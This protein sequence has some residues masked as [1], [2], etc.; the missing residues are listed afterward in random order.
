MPRNQTFDMLDFM[1]VAYPVL[2]VAGVCSITVSLDTFLN[3]CLMCMLVAMCFFAYVYMYRK[4][5]DPNFG[6]RLRQDVQ[7]LARYKER[8][9]LSS[10]LSI[11]SQSGLISSM[12]RRA[13][14]VALSAFSSNP[15]TILAEWPLYSGFYHGYPWVAYII[16]LAYSTS[17][18]WWE[19]A[20][21]AAMRAFAALQ[22]AII[23]TEKWV[24]ASKCRLRDAVVARLL[25]LAI[26]IMCIENWLAETRDHLCHRCIST[27]DAAIVYL[28]QVGSIVKQWVVN[29]IQWMF[30]QTCAFLRG[31]WNAIKDAAMPRLQRFYSGII[32]WL[33]RTA[34]AIRQNPRRVAALICGVA[35]IWLGCRYAP[36]TVTSS[37]DGHWRIDVT[38]GRIK[39]TFDWE[40]P[41]ITILT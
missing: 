13:V 25:R 35:L 19:T 14:I 17:D 20:Q 34:T 10:Y 16:S 11:L 21:D 22:S 7:A 3:F 39:G 12:W 26:A 8:V 1:L 23:A 4:K 18:F 6:A 2:Y 24:N 32:H 40:L 37:H 27:K 5:V 41:S 9:Q 15:T 36:W 30:N 28:L 33:Y 31:L 38:C 29:A